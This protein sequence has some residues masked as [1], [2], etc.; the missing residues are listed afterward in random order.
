MTEGT[1]HHRRMRRRQPSVEVTPSGQRV[2]DAVRAGHSRDS[3]R[4][5]VDAGRLQRP[6]R[7]IVTPPGERNDAERLAA[8]LLHVGP[9]AVAVIGSAALQHGLQGLPLGWVPQIAV[10]PG[11]EKRQREGIDLHFWDLAE[12]DLTVVDGIRC[13]RPRRTLADACRL[14][15]RTQAVALVDSA[16]HLGV[17]SEG[18]LDAIECLMSRRRHCV[19]GRRWLRQA[20][21]GAQ[22]P[23]ETRVRL[24]AVDAGLPPDALQWEIRD[25]GGLVL[26]YADLAYRLPRGR[27]LAVEADGQSVHSLPDALLHDRRRQNAF[28]S[29]AGV[30]VVRFTWEDTRTPAYI[31]SVL[32]PILNEAGWRPPR[33]P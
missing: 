18:E 25:A 15:P 14:L 21:V 33:R 5:D 23:L 8:A 17:V 29:A 27:I 20:R 3:L 13:T 10:P 26:G 12:A 16:L 11:L 1:T 22:S 6:H 9:E 24:I 32:R 28:L 19:T 7:G 30:T 31:P 4:R 2:A